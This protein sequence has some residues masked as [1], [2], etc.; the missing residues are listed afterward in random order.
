MNQW[1]YCA[2]DSAN[3]SLKNNARKAHQARLMLIHC[4][5]EHVNLHPPIKNKEEPIT[6][7][8]TEPE[9]GI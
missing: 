7:V 5:S 3:P 8:I 4:C 6:A 2:P 9:S 1:K